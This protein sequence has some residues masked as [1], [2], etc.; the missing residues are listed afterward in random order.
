MTLLEIYNIVGRFP[1]YA[2]LIEDWTKKPR[3]WKYTEGTTPSAYTEHV[4]DDDTDT[5]Q[6]DINRD[7]YQIHD[8]T[9]KEQFNKVFD[10]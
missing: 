8:L 3:Y 5:F 10:E 1:F 7:N 2:S 4:I 6:V 9:Y